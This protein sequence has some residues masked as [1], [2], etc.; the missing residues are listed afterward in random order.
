MYITRHSLRNYRN[1]AQLSFAPAAGINVIY[2]RNGVGK[3]NLLESLFYSATLRSFRRAKRKA[4]LGPATEPVLLETGLM[5][6]GSP[7]RLAVQI[8]REGNRLAVDGQELP[9]ARDFFGRW[10]PVLFSPEDHLLIKL[11]PEQRR[12]YFDMILSFQRPVY[13]AQLVELKRVLMQKKQ[14]LLLIQQGQ[15]GEETLAAWNESLAQAAVPVMEARA[16]LCRRLGGELTETYRRLSGG[17]EEVGIEYAPSCSGGDL[18]GQLERR[19]GDEIERGQCLL[20]PHRDDYRFSLGRRGLRDFASQGEEKSF[21]LALKLLEIDLAEEAAGEP[22]VL[23][24]DDLGSEL[25]PYRNRS[26]L[27]LLRDRPLQIFITTT[28]AAKIEFSPGANDRLF[29]LAEGAL[30]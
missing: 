9:K 8:E 27:A 16:A 15:G 17:G 2:G 12:N 18:V 30:G 10:I 1:L 19:R 5:R 22:P 11:G 29:H 4:L 20:G 25:D 13:L 6:Q 24:I 3:T 21:L 23:L 26:V 7:V 28:D 14:L